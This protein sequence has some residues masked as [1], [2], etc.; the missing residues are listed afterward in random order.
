MGLLPNLAVVKFSP[1]CMRT[2]AE[3]G[4]RDAAKI[5]GDVRLEPIARALRGVW[6]RHGLFA[7]FAVFA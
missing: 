6:R 1:L 3:L 7:V 4:S 5:A 2:A